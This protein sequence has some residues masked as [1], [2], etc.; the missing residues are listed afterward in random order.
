MITIITVFI[1]FAQHKSDTSDDIS[2]DD[3]IY[4][5]IAAILDLLLEIYLIIRNII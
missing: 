3:A 1:I 4:S 5:G 2:H